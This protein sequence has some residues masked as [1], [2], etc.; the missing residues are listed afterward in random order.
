MELCEHAAELC[1]I[2]TDWL[3]Q[4]D[5]RSYTKDTAITGSFY[6]YTSAQALMG[7]LSSRK[8]W[9]TY[10]SCFAD[11]AELHASSPIFRDAAKQ[12][13]IDMPIEGNTF[14]NLRSL[15]SY[16]L[17]RKS[18][19]PVDSPK[20]RWLEL[21]GPF[22]ACFSTR[23]DSISHWQLYASQGQGYRFAVPA[24]DGARRVIYEE[25]KLRE[26]AVKV[27]Q[28]AKNVAATRDR[29]AETQQGDM[30]AI[31][32]QVDRLTDRCERLL[33]EFAA[34]YKNPEYAHEDEWRTVI[35]GDDLKV[36]HR[37]VSGCIVPYV[38][39]KLP[40]FQPGVK[41]PP[42]IRT[43]PAFP[44]EALPAAETG[45]RSILNCPDAVVEKSGHPYL[46]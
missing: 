33:L 28:L 6:H 35:W 17:K 43:G 37:G 30:G 3:S 25:S 18:H 19:D 1:S 15:R 8:I 41:M 4:N 46:P 36:E 40:A 39:I 13:G 27:L 34:C 31:W 29:L 16:L 21:R 20:G 26:W 23:E 44:A 9:A 10:A 24:L 12:I 32:N 45:I 7:I 42:F 14:H 22:V 11:Q 2:E 5:A 38:E